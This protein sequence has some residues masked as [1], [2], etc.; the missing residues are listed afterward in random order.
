MSVIKPESTNKGSEKSKGEFFGLMDNDEEKIKDILAEQL[1]KEYLL[2]PC[3]NDKALETYCMTK[4]ADRKASIRAVIMRPADKQEYE[5]LFFIRNI[6]SKHIG[7]DHNLCCTPMGDHVLLV[8]D[9]IKAEEIKKKLRTIQEIISKCFG[10]ETEMVYSAPVRLDEGVEVYERLKKCVG[11]AFYTGKKDMLRE[12]K[13][14]ENTAAPIKVNYVSIENAVKCGDLIRTE[15][16]IS[17]FF[18]NIAL[19]RPAPAIAKTYCLELYVCIIRCCGADKIDHYMKGIIKIQEFA[20]LEEIK[21]YIFEKAREIVSAN[22][23][24]QNKIYSALIAETV[25]IIDENIGNEELSLRWLAGSILYTNVDYLGKL[26]KKEVGKNFSH[27]VMEKRMELAKQ[28]IFEGRNDKIYE[29]AEK[30]GYGSNSQYFSQVF[31]KYTGVS[32]VEYKELVRA[33]DFDAG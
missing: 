13:I 20:S 18:E 5:D 1:Y 32:P 25:K 19:C 22:S 16:L 14:R 9:I 10:C 28:L 30:V 12:E 24:A 2:A 27:Y 4:G 21:R 26:F 23:P 33:M 15:T 7:K 3:D 6:A 11:Y 8:T 29:V 31:K 17:E